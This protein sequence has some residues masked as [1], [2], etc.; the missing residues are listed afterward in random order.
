MISQELLAD[1]SA[2]VRLNPSVSSLRPLFPALLNPALSTL[3]V[4]YPD[5][6]AGQAV[7]FERLL[8]RI[9]DGVVSGSG[10]YDERQRSQREEYAP[11]QRDPHGRETLHLKTRNRHRRRDGGGMGEMAPGSPARQK[12][13]YSNIRLKALPRGSATRGS[14]PEPPP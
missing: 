11:L 5:G 3:A 4:T 12:N 13:V 6:K 8:D 1:V 14:Q 7:V 9:V 10:M 2:A